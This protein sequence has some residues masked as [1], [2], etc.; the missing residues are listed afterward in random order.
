MNG[1][2]GSER[3]RTC[4]GVRHGRGPTKENDPEMEIVGTS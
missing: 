2:G 4:S 3:G 1:I